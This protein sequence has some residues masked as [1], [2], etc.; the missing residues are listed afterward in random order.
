[1]RA[2]LGKGVYVGGVVVAGLDDLKLRDVVPGK[3]KKREKLTKTQIYKFGKAVADALDKT[4]DPSRVSLKRV[5]VTAGLDSGL[6]VSKVR[7]LLPSLKPTQIKRYAEAAADAEPRAKKQRG[8]PK[9][10]TKTPLDIV[11]LRLEPHVWQNGWSIKHNRP[12]KHFTGTKTSMAKLVGVNARTF[13]RY[14]R[15]GRRG[16]GMSKQRGGKCP[17]CEQ[18]DTRVEPLVNGLILGLREKLLAYSETFFDSYDA[19]VA[20][21]PDFSE[22]N[23]KLAASPL[24]LQT[25]MSY[26]IERAKSLLNDFDEAGKLAKAFE[27]NFCKEGGHYE[28]VVAFQEGHFKL[29]HHQ[30]AA[31]NQQYERP[32]PGAMHSAAD[33]ADRFFQY[34]YI[35][36]IKIKL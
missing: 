25:F 24:Y 26:C 19:T 12:I 11:D 18:F 14:Y 8:R 2:R 15:R 17:Y 20:A 13:Q 4:S 9:G 3:R 23:F 35:F 36:K 22:P 7:K 5:V 16:F 29:W 27:K 34:F 33:F 30:A 28:T 6:G 21:H 1:M 10:W 32:A 31:F